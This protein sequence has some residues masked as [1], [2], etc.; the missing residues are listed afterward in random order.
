[1]QIS[2][3]QVDSGR[4]LLLL[5]GKYTSLKACIHTLTVKTSDALSLSTLKI[6]TENIKNM[7]KIFVIMQKRKKN[8]YINYFEEFI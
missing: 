4:D 6:D 8:V 2:H 5:S 7:C 1:M 3:K